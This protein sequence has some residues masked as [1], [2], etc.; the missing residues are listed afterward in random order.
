MKRLFFLACILCAL[1]ANAAP[2]ASALLPFSFNFRSVNVAQAVS[3]IFSE[4]LSGPYVIDPEVL[5]DER[6][7]SFRYESSY[8]EARPFILS[9]LASLGLNV[10]RRNGVDYVS[11]KVA[12]E[13]EG[14][15]IELFVYRT[16]FRDAGYLTD[17]L[18]P[19]FHGSFTAKKTISAASSDKV[20]PGSVPPASAAAL[21]DRKAIDTIVFSGTKLE[22]ERLRKF[23]TMV[24]VPAGSVV[25]KG[26]VYE[27]TT[28]KYDSSAFS[29]ALSLL[30]GRVGGSLGAAKGQSD[31]AVSIKVAGLDAAYSALA[32]DS[33]FHAVST[34]TVRVQSGAQAKLKVGQSVPTLGAV[35]YAQGS[36]VPIQSVDYRSSG[37]ILTLSPTVRE[38]QIELTINQEISDFAATETGVNGS[39][40]LSERSL[41]TT[42]SAQDGEIIVLGG[43]TQDKHTAQTSGFKFLPSFMR[44][45]G[46]N[47]LRTEI[48]LVLQVSVVG[49]TNQ[50]R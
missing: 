21:I 14:S 16:K 45:S 7:V 8:G 25:V 23:I 9:F 15:D 10:E 20:Q 19:L 5:S 24:D 39:P 35:S 37:V 41:S 34:P 6:I 47:D 42:V 31:G 48:L 1:S 13:L 26:V 43:L 4:A 11:R 38:S 46:V 22:A 27:V 33:R 44:N 32:N 17:L 3:V 40:T 29:L 28:G 49:P 30:G 2:K 18:S 12:V 50:L 36:A